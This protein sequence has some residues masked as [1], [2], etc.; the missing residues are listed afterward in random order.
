M[1]SLRFWFIA[2]SVCEN[3]FRSSLRYAKFSMNMP[4]RPSDSGRSTAPGILEPVMMSLKA[5]SLRV[6]HTRLS[7]EERAAQEAH[8]RL[9]GCEALL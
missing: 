2:S 7:T 9:R 6:D 3:R 1:H 4:E 8:A 5:V